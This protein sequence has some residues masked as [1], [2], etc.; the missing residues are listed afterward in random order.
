MKIKRSY[1]GGKV[2]AI[3]FHQ[4]RPWLLASFH[5]GEI[6]IFDYQNDVVL[7]KYKDYF[8]PVRAVDFH[9]SETL[10]VAGGDDGCVRIYD[11][12]KEYC[13]FRFIEHTDYIRSVQFHNT[14]PLIVTASDDQTI[15]IFN[16]KTRT[17][18][19]SISGHDM[20]V[21]SA[22]FHPELP[23]IVSCSLDENIFVWDISRLLLDINGPKKFSFGEV[24]LVSSSRDNVGGVSFVSWHPTQNKIIAST[25]ERKIMIFSEKLSEIVTVH[26]HEKNITSVKFMPLLDSIVSCSEDGTLK[27]LRQ[28]S[29]R[30]VETL[31]KPTKFWGL[32]IHKSLPLIAA[33]HDS[34]F[35]I[36]KA[37]KNRSAFQRI[38]P[39]VFVYYDEDQLRKFDYAKTSNIV[40]CVGKNLS[41]NK[42]AK[43]PHSIQY[44]ESANFAMIDF[45]NKFSLHNLELGSRANFE[46]IDGVS[47]VWLN[48]TTL[49]YM[50]ENFPTIYKREIKNS[51]AQPV[52]VDFTGRLFAAGNDSV[53][54]ASESA[55][56][57][58]DVRKEKKK[59]FCEIPH[60]KQIIKGD[61]IAIIARGSLIISDKD[62][63]NQVLIS[64]I[65]DPKSGLWFSDIFFFTTR[66]H[67]Q[68]C[69]KSGEVGTLKALDSLLYLADISE[70]QAILIGPD[71]SFKT[72]DIDINEA[73]FK[74]EI[75]RR[76]PEAAIRLLSH[77][78]KISISQS[79]IR[80]TVNA[81]YPSVAKELCS[82]SRQKFEMA[83]ESFDIATAERFIDTHDK[84]ACTVLAEAAFSCGR[85]REAEKYYS[86]AGCEDKLAFILLLSGQTQKLRALMTASNDNSLAL[87]IALWLGDN[88]FATKILGEE[89]AGL[90]EHMVS[91]ARNLPDYRVVDNWP[92]LEIR[93]ENLKKEVIEEES[94]EEN[95]WDDV[96]VEQFIAEKEE[97]AL[98]YKGRPA[99]ESW[100]SNRDSPLSLIHRGLFGDAIFVLKE[101]IGL[102]DASLLR[103]IFVEEYIGSHMM[104]NSYTFPIKPPENA[105]DIKSALDFVS[106]GKFSQ[107]LSLFR[108]LLVRMCLHP[109]ALIKETAIY[110]LA[111][112]ML[113]EAESVKKSDAKR[114]LELLLRVSSLHLRDEH[115][116]LSAKTALKACTRLRCFL[117]ARKL[118]SA[119]PEN[120]QLTAPS[121]GEDSLDIRFDPRRRISSSNFEYIEGKISECPFCGSIYS[122]SDKGN[123]CNICNIAEIGRFISHNFQ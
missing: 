97:P 72:F 13:I 81:G 6:I 48:R 112:E 1:E 35:Y 107:A 104:V 73:L 37:R 83:V 102:K 47:P 55:V 90:S 91:E 77:S 111:M 71:S 99:E 12:H 101:Q 86:L 25:P 122:L 76:D 68:Y 69:L 74:N 10:F 62:F 36:I 96:Y 5:T 98:P 113:I 93:E 70:R 89:A 24:L 4:I 52:H 30:T 33:C 18:I 29:C 45:G 108:S 23:Y 50:S 116:I 57:F 34:G 46:T 54:I 103:D 58:F 65:D 20:I 79:I 51:D 120:I 115:R 84:D 38:K 61:K 63:S 39:G 26:A 100:D 11:F 88:E 78:D 87:Q 8:G 110:V 64:E 95:S 109:S 67:L 43:N 21:M 32:S 75:L 80:Y 60:V 82:D 2:K 121:S 123:I 114:R 42:L 53:Y 40:M 19:Y 7:Q 59:A 31:T 92:L 41:S 119:L 15:G 85:F 105:L 56:I 44:N 3:C 118:I 22:F 16:Y 28:D 106:A 94:E 49:C 117:T 9:P 66:N 14:L 17:Q 27:I